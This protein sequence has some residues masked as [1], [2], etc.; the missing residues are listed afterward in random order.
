VLANY[1]KGIVFEPDYESFFEP[2][3]AEAGIEVSF[4]RDGY[5][6]VEGP[7]IERIL[8]YTNMADEK[9]FAFFQRFMRE[10]GIIAKLEE[11]GIREGDTVQIYELEF[12]Y[13]A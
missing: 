5:F 2:E 9:G 6:R 8:G 10:K 7:G 13:Y 12:D 4:V 11:L 1:P 3:K